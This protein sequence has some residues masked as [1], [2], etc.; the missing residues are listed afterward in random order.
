MS[1]GRG[2]CLLTV[3]KGSV[4]PL[5]KGFCQRPAMPKVYAEKAIAALKIAFQIEPSLARNGWLEPDFNAL[6]PIPEYLA[7]LARNVNVPNAR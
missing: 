4:P 1:R 6:Y 7:L 5:N 2:P 3:H